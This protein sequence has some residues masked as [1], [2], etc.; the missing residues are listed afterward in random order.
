MTLTDALFW[1]YLANAVVLVVHEMDAVRWEEWSLL[2]LPGGEPGFLALHVPPLI[3]LLLGLV[4]LAQGTWWGFAI[5]LAVGVSGLSAYGIHT[6]QRR[7]G[8]PAFD[9][10]PS[11]LILWTTLIVSVPQVLLSLIGLL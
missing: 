9:T 11:R 1:V 5:G 10:P 4:G 8:V 6:F 7:S 2:H 3:L